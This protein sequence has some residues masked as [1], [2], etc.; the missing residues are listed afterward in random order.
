MS[1]LAFTIGAFLLA[2][3]ILVTVHEFGHFW[4]ARRLGVRVL[5]FSLGFGRSLL[6]WRRPGDPTEYVLAAL[7]LGGY[8]KMADEREEP[9]APQDLPFAFNRQPLW[10]RTAI[11]LAGPLCNFLFAFLVYWLVLMAGETGTRAEIGEVPPASIAAAAGFETGDTLLRIGARPTPTWTS[12]WFALLN[13][14]LDGR[15]IPVRVRA[16]SGQERQLVL[17]GADLAGLDPGRGLLDAIGLASGRP[18][19]PPV[20]GDLMP[21][22]PAALAGLRPGD[23]I[24]RID[25]QPIE[26]WDRL[27]EVMQASAE[28]TLAVEIERAGE[29]QRLWLRPRT[30][31]HDGQTVGRIGAAPYIPEDLLERERVLV[32]LGP[33]TA[34]GAAVVRVVDVSV[35]T[36]RILTRML[37]GRASL[38]NLSSPIGIADTAGKTAAFGIEPFVKFLAVLSI[39]LGLLNLLPIPLLDGGHLLFFG[40]EAALGRPLSEAAQSVGLRIGLALLIGLM[41]LAFYADMTRLLG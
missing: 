19:L 16:T 10:K 22:E 11:V 21:D 18:R 25:D 38:D 34:A 9:V 40:L 41:S 39:S 28:Q 20:L 8:V 32:R 4:V 13:A 26:N 23:R 6:T 17:S 30:A 29:T 27:V 5:R 37:T 7:P 14:T 12:A 33:F 2:I 35:L 36:L 31:L 15:D 1:S 24:L 3:G